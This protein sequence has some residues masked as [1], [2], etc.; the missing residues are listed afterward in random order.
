MFLIASWGVLP[1]GF[2]DRVTLPVC[3]MFPRAQE[4]TFIGLGEVGVDRFGS[5]NH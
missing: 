5:F 1:T 2:K 3:N 4:L